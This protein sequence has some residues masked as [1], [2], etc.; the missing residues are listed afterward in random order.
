MPSATFLSYLFC[1]SSEHCA[2]VAS[3][4]HLAQR[5][6]EK[7]LWHHARKAPHLSWQGLPLSV[8]VAASEALLVLQEMSG[9]GL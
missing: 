8:V 4:P 7:E 5:D 9:T 1:C 6:T 2:N 3:S